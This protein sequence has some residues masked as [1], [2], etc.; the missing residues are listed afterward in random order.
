[1]CY[2]FGDF[3]L[4]DSSL[5]PNFQLFPSCSLQ[6]SE[7]RQPGPDLVRDRVV[8]AALLCDC[9]LFSFSLRN[10]NLSQAVTPM[11]LYLQLETADS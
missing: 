2:Y 9:D 10:P 5:H 3:Y 7:C 4:Q 11:V 8:Q 6:T 1:M